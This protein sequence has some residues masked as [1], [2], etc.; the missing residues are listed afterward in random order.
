MDRGIGRPDA[1]GWETR[2]AMEYIAAD[3]GVFFARGLMGRPE[4]FSE[5]R[6]IKGERTRRCVIARAFD[7]NP[8]GQGGLL[9]KRRARERG[10]C[11]GGGSLRL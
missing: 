4:G 8:S 10:W 6:V 7:E 11:G 9:L 1:S 2:I 5:M 3:G